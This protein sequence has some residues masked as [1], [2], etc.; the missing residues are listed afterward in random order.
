MFICQLCGVSQPI[1][2]KANK[3]TLE[4]RPRTYEIPVLDHQGFE[5][6]SYETVGSE[7]VREVT[8]CLSCAIDA[9]KLSNAENP[10]L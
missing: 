9:R 10:I 8:A 5:V 2:T 1:F 6:D 4:T 7:I 3:V